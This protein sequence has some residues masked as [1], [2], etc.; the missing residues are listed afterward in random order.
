MSDLGWEMV[1]ACS[2]EGGWQERVVIQARDDGA[3][4]DDARDRFCV[5]LGRRLNRTPYRGFIILYIWD[6]TL[7]I[8]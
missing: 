1:F 7:F 3:G 8:F 5:Y 4:G 2:P 6:Y